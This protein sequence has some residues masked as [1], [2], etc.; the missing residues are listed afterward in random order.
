LTDAGTK[1]PGHEYQGVLLVIL[2][3]CHSYGG[4][5]PVVSY[6][7][8]ESGTISMNSFVE[9]ASSWLA[10]LVEKGIYSTS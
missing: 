9:V 8:L 10:F 1:L 2:I 7:D 5:L 3:V 4:I 6:Q